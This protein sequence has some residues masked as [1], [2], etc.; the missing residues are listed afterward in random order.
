M[1]RYQT[2]VALGTGGTAE[3]Y[4]AYDPTLKRHV[5][6]KFLRRDDPG[7]VERMFREARAQAK[8]DH[9][10]IC[11]VYEVGELDGRPFI[12]MQ[13][14]DGVELG[15][16]ADQ[17]TRDAKVQVMWQVVQA[18]HAAHREGLIHRDLKPAN[19]M[20]QGELGRYRPVVVDFGLVWDHT[21]D[22]T[23]VTQA[24]Q[25]LGT[26]PYMAPE[27]V[28]GRR[29]R[30]DRRTDVYGLGATLY[31][32][33]A[34]RPL[35]VADRSVE[36]LFKIVHE[37]PIPLRR[38]DPE[39]PAD[40]E[41]IVAKCLE[42]EPHRRYDSARALG[43]DLRAYLDGEPIAARPPSFGY[44]LVRTMHRHRLAVTVAL[45]VAFLSL[46]V[47]GVLRWRA[48]QR[49]RYEQHFARAGQ[50]I[51]WTQRA[52]HMSAKHDIGPSQAGVRQ[53]IAD[54]EVELAEAG[55]LGEGP[56][57]Y[58]IGSAY[59]AL[60]D[61]TTAQHHLEAAWRLGYRTPEVAYTLGLVLGRQYEALVARANEL[62]D[63]DLR[64][65]RLRQAAASH[66]D[67]AIEYLAW[68]R[69]TDTV[70]TGYVEA[71]LA[72]YEGD[73]DAARQGL[74]AARAKFPWLYETWL[75]EGRLLRKRGDTER[76]RQGARHSALE[77]YREAEKAFRA[78][79]GSAGS[80]PRGYV[81]LC[82]LQASWMRMEAQNP[83]GMMDDLYRRA[84][85]ACG[86]AQ[87]V[88]ATL[89]EAH[90]RLAI[91]HRIW[92][93]YLI[94]TGGQP[95]EALDEAVRV[96]ERA[97]ALAADDY[98]VFATLG[99][100][101]YQWGSYLTMS[102]AGD[103]RGHMEAAQHALDRALEL[104]PDNPVV[105]SM[106]GSNW[107][108]R[109]I[110]EVRN[111][112]AG[113][114]SVDR[115]IEHHN[116]AVQSSPDSFNY[117]YNL[118]GAHWVRAYI[119]LERGID[120]RSSV[121][122]ALDHYRRSIEI[123]PDFDWG[124]LELGRVLAGLAHLEFLTGGDALPR[125]EQAIASAQ[126]ALE[127]NSEVGEFYNRLISLRVQVADL[128]RRRGDDPGADLEQ[129]RHRL[130][131]MEAIN[132]ERLEHHAQRLAIET[133]ALRWALQ[134]GDP[135]DPTLEAGDRALEQMGNFARDS[136]FYGSAADYLV[137]KAAGQLDRGDNPGRTIERGLSLVEEALE[138]GIEIPR[139][140]GFRGRLRTLAG[141]QEGDV[142]RRTELFDLAEEDLAE[143]LRQNRWLE[144]DLDP[145]LVDVRRRAG[146][147]PQWQEP[148]D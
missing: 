2:A 4:K 38:L 41:V 105:H 13:Y 36:L 93:R 8:L 73:L 55:S 97:A 138:K 28:E 120:A 52:V 115:A 54:L 49:L 44:R 145:W 29:D 5:A 81:G 141:R 75:L 118:A 136:F 7:L 114:G 119:E 123:N 106:A 90:R 70:P 6:L 53:R 135:I 20:V 92:A 131:Q 82:S 25:V 59:A 112:F 80:D 129:A 68:G 12:A 87:E 51:A 126:H 113:E 22:E 77:S 67:P 39:L 107:L 89:A 42:K 32:L 26:P 84:Q 102:R 43:A 83:T 79:I 94:W 139:F 47:M 133:V 40:L 95:E 78:A 14:I 111:G 69:S 127:L 56:A 21:S 74:V 86:E 24:G 142:D 46:V 48:D 37:D 101:H 132:P 3:I 72:F 110:Y 137:W 23:A 61:D 109:A 27:Q 9:A 85:E 121:Q 31:E 122:S 17:M 103:P 100:S 62:R 144:V 99:A 60:L 108:A 58:A 143:A 64:N 71:L 65:E 148:R 117:H 50:E 96:A 125:M 15:V 124:H 146:K 140:L 33:L 98:T 10:G 18:V 88:D 104:A 128:R 1:Q 66:R 34:R 16:A 147:L 57:Q 91:A 30:L 130:R 63:A 116:A 11:K 35:F 45:M 76:I 19:I 134:R